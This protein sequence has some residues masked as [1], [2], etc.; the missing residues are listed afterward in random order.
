MRR[1]TA[2]LVGMLSIAGLIGC[3]NDG[4]ET[5]GSTAALEYV[6]PADLEGRILY[7]DKTVSP[8]PLTAEE[9][10]DT[11]RAIPVSVV[12]YADHAIAW[13]APFGHAQIG[14]DGAE[15]ATW[16]V[17][18]RAR[19]ER[20]S[21]VA[22]DA[23]ARPSTPA[24]NVTTPQGVD[25]GLVPGAAIPDGIDLGASLPSVSLPYVVIDWLD[26][27]A[28]EAHALQE[29]GPVVHPGCL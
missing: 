18:G 28:D 29:I 16:R 4:D 7:L 21:V 13:S 25:T 2:V 17:L 12:F 22:P 19:E 1:V 15:V 5:G 10:G 8:R 14:V 23:P 26:D 9:L 3:A 20:G 24:G 6:R 11:S 27:F